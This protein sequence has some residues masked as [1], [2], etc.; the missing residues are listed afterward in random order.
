[1]IPPFARVIMA[2]LDLLRHPSRK[3]LNWATAAIF[4]LSSCYF[5]LTAINQGR[6]L[7]PKTEDEGSYAIGMQMMAH[8]RLWMPALPLPEFFDSFYIVVKPVYA[9]IYFPGTAL[10]F[11]PTVWL[12]LPT[13]AMAAMVSGFVVV[14]VYRIIAELIDGAAAALAALLT[15]SL[16]W[17]RVY[18][19]LLTSHVPM[20]MFALA[21]FYA[22]LQWRKQRRLR[23]AIV[24][25]AAAGWGAITRPADAFIYAVPIGFALLCD[26]FRGSQTDDARSVRF[27]GSAKKLGN[28]SLSPVIRGEGRV[29]G[30]PSTQKKCPLTPT[31]SPAYRGEGAGD[32]PRFDKCPA[33]K[34]DPT[35]TSRHLFS[36]LAVIVLAAIPFLVLQLV[37]D[38]G[39][40][41]HLLRT[42]YSY[43]LVED[44]PGSAFGIHP[45]D[46]A[47]APHS[48]LA[49]K[50]ESYDKFVRPYLAG[51]T[52]RQIPRN[53]GKTYLPMIV[54]TTLPCRLM[55][56]FVPLGFL[57]LRGAKRWAL[58]ATLP[59]FIL[60]YALNPF[61][62][63]HYAILIIPAVLLL[64]LL[65][66]QALAETWPRLQ[67]PIWAGFAVMVIVSGFTSFWEIDRYLSPLETRVNDE[68]FASPYLHTAEFLNDS[69][70]VEKPAV[71]LF[72]YQP[73]GYNEEPVYNLNVPWPDDAAVIRA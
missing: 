63:E 66:G 52:L 53:W 33:A 36:S 25:G 17:F 35:Q 37:F 3:T 58:A 4:V 19:I 1:M 5:I 8:G 47:A 50:Q 54:D 73:G 28:L 9:S 41:G 11:A 71:V 10:L 29:R 12:H 30:S 56:V 21:M 68:T 38:Y 13:W 20:L 55:L 49:E 6:D 15:V 46:P 16:S 2:G 51:H 64:T 70:E 45:Y 7:F 65:G 14:L 32:P 57:G 24:L 61:F 59:I 31:L 60:I 69:K 72:T 18:S 39:V 26:L 43:Y 23:W 62:L 44:Q 40:T 48:V 42:P 22:W 34:A 27:V 67:R